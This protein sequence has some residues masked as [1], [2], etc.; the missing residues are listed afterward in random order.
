MRGLI[1]VGLAALLT[2][3]LEIEETI[4]ILPNG[5]GVQSMRIK[6]P[7]EVL[8]RLRR[9]VL[10]ARP[11][12]SSQERDITAVFDE[13]RAASEFAA[14]GLRLRKHVV[15]ERRSSRSL[16]VELG[17]PDLQTLA[18]SPLGGGN[19]DWI[20]KDGGQ[21]KTALFF[22]P[23][24]KAA[25][26]EAQIR[27]KGFEKQPTAPR[28]LAFFRKQ[29]AAMQDLDLSLT[30]NLPGRVLRKSANL[31]AGSVPT[32]VVARVRAADIKTPKDLLALLAPCFFVEFDS[33]KCSFGPGSDRAKVGSGG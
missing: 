26:K 28:M 8:G 14:A 23:M 21:G 33:R 12:A 1:A 4:T 31:R 5:S 16:D 29:K 6:I 25:W 20:L 18:R 2:G 17:F 3:C 24:G 7:R 27:V 15:R 22:F 9:Q 10:A 30:L 13:K 11:E 19:S 32:Q